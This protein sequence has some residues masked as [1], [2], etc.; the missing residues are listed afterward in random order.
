M[1]KSLL[2]I[3]ALN[4]IKLGLLITLLNTFFLFRH[5]TLPKNSLNLIEQLETKL[6]DIRYKIRGSESMS[7]VVGAMTAD[8]KSIERFGRWPFRR[9]IYEQAF[10]NLKNAGVKWIGL[11]VLFSEP[12]RR[13]L[14][15]SIPDLQN[16]FYHKNKIVDL[17]STQFETQIDNLITKSPGDVSLGKAIENFH[18]V[19]QSYFY[20]E[21]Q[22]QVLKSS[23]E[24]QSSFAR[25]QNSFIDFTDLP[26]NKTLDDYK[27]LLS[28]GA[29][30]NTSLISGHNRY[31]GFA[32]NETD[33]DGLVRKYILVKSIKPIDKSGNILANT[34]LVPSLGL[35]MAANYLGSGII[36]HFDS[37]GIESIELSPSETTKQPIK[38]PVYFD[39]NGQMLMN[40]YGMFHEIPQISLE[41]AYDNHLPKKLPEI[42][43]Y[44]GVGTGTNDK[45]PSP[46]DERFDGV[47]FHVTAVE[48]ILTQNF[49]KR[50]LK[51][52]F[53]ELS[54]LIISGLIFSIA[55]RY[56]SSLIAAVFIFSS[57]I[58]FYFI[59]QYFIFGKGTWYYVGMFYI[60]SIGIYICITVFKYFTEE[61][62]K[63]KVKGAFQHYLNPSVINKMIENPS[64][65]KL[66][67]EKKYLTVFFSD[68]RGFTTISEQLS[69]EKLTALLNEYFTPMTKIVFD[70][71]GLLDKYIGD[72][73]MA[74]WGAPVYFEDHADRAI[75]SSLQ[76]L[77]KLAILQKKW[78]SEGLPFL[79]V[80][81]GLNTGDMVVGNMGSEQRFDYTVLGDSVNLGS[82]IESINKNY[83][84]R[85]LCS[86][87]TKNALKNPELFLLRELDI[88]RVKGK[89]EPVK[90][91]E[92]MQF[93]SENKDFIKKI[94]QI[95][96]EGLN[97]YRSSQWDLA[98]EK[99]N[100]V[101]Q[102]RSDDGPSLEFIERCNYLRHKE[103]SAEEP[104]DGV[105]NFKTK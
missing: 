21:R 96:V 4:P 31:M 27:S 86:E 40:H 103:F 15:E 78:E 75:Q 37:S 9:D 47:G 42:L 84:T 6:Y 33:S 88:I 25:L 3:F 50:S 85:L 51:A 81:I 5:Y 62:E 13:S 101:I 74:V 36:V 32:N 17:T 99:F 28:Y 8:D 65:L 7:G 58:I 77:D 43:I 73:M 104:W 35:A 93:N 16:I 59:D 80:G 24:W 94:I 83:G 49:M 105:W 1:K 48:N 29:V 64:L 20:V 90:I 68:V 56:M 60:Q 39:G 30:T 70:S 41:E 92:V 61:R 18:N 72:A 2:R 91:F 76:M 10:K 100:A 11:D 19:V 53:I 52:P 34:V 67:G 102:L 55:L 57:M 69:P 66:G 22:N 26:P 54:V 45:R 97:Y 44:G 98:I 89:T 87:F 63:R 95:F 82:R 71:S 46:F 14:E 12:S 23:Y 38:I 79:D